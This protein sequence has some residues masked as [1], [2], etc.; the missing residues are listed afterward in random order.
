MKKILLII[1]FIICITFVSAQT[2]PYHLKLLAVEE[3]E[4]HYVGSDADLYLELKEGGFGRVFLETT[5]LTKLD[6]QVSTRFAKEIAC[7]HLKLN[8]NQY[9]FIYTIRARSSIIGGPSAGAAIS[10]LTAIAVLD[11]D[12]DQSIAVT[13][14]INSGGLIGSVGGVK[15]KLEAAARANLKKVLIPLG[16]S[17]NDTNLTSYSK[18]LGIEVVEVLD[19]NQVLVELTG[20]EFPQ[21]NFTIMQDPHYKEIMQGLQQDLCNRTA[22]IKEE[23]ARNKIELDNETTITVSEADQKSVNATGRG[24]YYSAASFCFGNN[25][26]L[27][28]YYYQQKNASLED[29]EKLFQMLQGRNKALEQEISQQPIETISS[30]QALTIVKERLQDVQA[31]IKLFREKHDEPSKYYG[32]LAYAEERYYSANSWKAFFGMGGKKYQVDANSLKALC[33]QKI[34]EAQDRFQYVSFFIPLEYLTGLQH[35][36]TSAQEANQKGEDAL[37][38]ISA[39]QA[40]ADAD[41]IMGSMGLENE[42]LTKFLAGKQLAV[43][44]VLAENTAEGTFP[45][46]GYS[47]YQYALSLKDQEPGTALV[48]LEYALEMSDLGIYFPEQPQFLEKVQQKL[49]LNRDWVLVTEGFLAGVFVVLVAWLGYNVVKRMK[50]AG[51]KKKR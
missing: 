33:Y 44:R 23:L 18:D 20:A 17:F 26:R 25:I 11:L 42:T 21:D 51:K 15:E 43:E 4:N 37:C 6:T 19:L 46:L 1:C 48:Y 45:I 13:G 3:Q 8:C 12:Y 41:A 47:Y 31:Q 14:T 27:K 36:L 16:S 10:A 2:T 9:D 34:S 28:T 5:P 40:K 49:S 22:K 29:L 39:L 50:K 38:F 7:S 35:K 32:V 24:D 30:L